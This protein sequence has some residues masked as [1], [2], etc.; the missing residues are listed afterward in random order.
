M[1]KYEVSV[2]P[3]PGLPRGTCM[4]H[5]GKDVLSSKVLFIRPCARQSKVSSDK[6]SKVRNFTLEHT[7]GGLR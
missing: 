1:R 7:S 5:K 3:R 4:E 2:V 6:H